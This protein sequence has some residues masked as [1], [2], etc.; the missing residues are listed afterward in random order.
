MATTERVSEGAGVGV[1]GQLFIQVDEEQYAPGER[2]TGS[3]FVTITEPTRCKGARSYT[4]IYVRPRRPERV[5][6][7]A[8]AA[9]AAAYAELAV[10]VSG[11]ESLSWDEG[12][13]S[14]TIPFEK[15]LLNHKVGV[16]MRLTTPLQQQ[17]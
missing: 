2:V 15:E 10:I 3:V 16:T 9:T 12:E 4:D 6:V 1:R 8:A 14:T 5:A 11:R 17:R 13:S 7:A